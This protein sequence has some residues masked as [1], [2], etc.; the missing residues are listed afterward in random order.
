MKKYQGVSNDAKQILYRPQKLAKFREIYWKLNEYVEERD[1]D[2]RTS[3]D[4]EKLRIRELKKGNIMKTKTPAEHRLIEKLVS[5]IDV[6]MQED[7]SS[8]IL[9]KVG[10]DSS[11][12]LATA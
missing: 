4:E 7:A 8:K 11:V 9:E 3:K 2:F 10:I 1:Q 5:V 12:P 6:I